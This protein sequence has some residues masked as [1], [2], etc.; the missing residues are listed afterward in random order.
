MGSTH[1]V[2]SVGFGLGWRV[3]RRVIH[4][5]GSGLEMVTAIGHR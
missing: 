3:D 5:L 1:T 2:A 4:R